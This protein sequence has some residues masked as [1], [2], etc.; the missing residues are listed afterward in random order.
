[1]TML[2]NHVVLIT[3]ASS[4]IGEATALALATRGARLVLA[5]RRTDRLKAL[6]KRILD[7]GGQALSLPC[8]VTRLDQVEALFHQAMDTFGQLDV[9]INNAGIMPNAPMA[10]CRVDDWDAM[11]DVN[12]KGLL[13]GIAQ[14]L[15]IMLKQKSGHII[16]VSSVAGRKVFPGGVVYCATKHAVHAITEGLRYELA[17]MGAND[18]NTIRVTTIAPGV[19]DTELPDSIKHDATREGFK[20]YVQSLRNPLTSEDIASSIVFAMEAPVHMGVNE[21]LV[22]PQSQI[23]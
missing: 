5:A 22:R 12:V 4:G 9:L 19:V 8:D 17:E 18:G 2:A 23:R 6:E 16:N 13:Y 14:A 21:I 3:G 15:P 20:G 7:Q 1:M 11:I 10:S